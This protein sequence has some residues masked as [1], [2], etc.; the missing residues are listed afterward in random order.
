MSERSLPQ[1]LED[2]LSP[3]TTLLMQVALA[4]LPDAHLDPWPA[5]RDYAQDRGQST[6][7]ATL[8]TLHVL[9]LIRTIYMILESVDLSRVAAA[10]VCWL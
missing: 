10:C 8:P 6:L 2:K 3:A 1:F 9:C 7:G 4:L 5:L